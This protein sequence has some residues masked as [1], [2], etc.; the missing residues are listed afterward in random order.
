MSEPPDPLEAELAALRPP[1]VSPELRR[2]IAQRLAGA[3][4]TRPRRPVWLALA[5]GLAAACLAGILLGWGGGRRHEPGPNDRPQPAPPALV[6]DPGPTL[7][8]CER[9]LARSPEELD[10]LLDKDA[11]VAPGPQPEPVRIGAFGRSDL[12]LQALLGED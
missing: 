12:D 9:A 8:A 10:A 1:E 3:P 4:P 5:G 2:R 6:E 11:G 7:L